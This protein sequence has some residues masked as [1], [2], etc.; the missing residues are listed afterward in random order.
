[1]SWARGVRAGALALAGALAGCAHYP[2]NAPLGAAGPVAD[3]RFP[4]A[5]VLSKIA[6]GNLLGYPL[7]KPPEY[8][9]C[10]KHENTAT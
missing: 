9:E 6:S 7:P 3:Y 4:D 1:M 10:L 5:V 2:L 8:P